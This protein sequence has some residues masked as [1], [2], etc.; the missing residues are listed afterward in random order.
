MGVVLLIVVI[1]A[2]GV[3]FDALKQCYVLFINKD[4]KVTDIL[5]GLYISLGLFG[6]FFG[7]VYLK[8][9]IA[10]DLTTWFI[11]PVVMVFVPSLMNSF[12]NYI[13]TSFR[14]FSTL[15]LIS[16]V[17]SGLLLLLCVIYLLCYY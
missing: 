16:V 12:L 14:Y 13:N 4:I 9:G 17:T 5:N 2:L 11:P 3:S 15:L 6:I 7:Y 1:I 10:N 8:K